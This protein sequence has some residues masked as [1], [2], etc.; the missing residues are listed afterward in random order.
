MTLMPTPP[1]RPWPP[2]AVD[3]EAGPRIGH[4]VNAH[5]V[6]RLRRAAGIRRCWLRHK[7]KNIDVHGPLAHCQHQRCARCGYERY[8]PVMP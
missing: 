4:P 3:P 6:N 5:R 1:D 7:W 8:F 2:L